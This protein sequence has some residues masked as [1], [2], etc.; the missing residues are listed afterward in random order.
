MTALINIAGQRFGRLLVIERCGSRGRKARW[1]CRCD[2]GAECTPCSEELRQGKTTSCG[3][4][5][6]EDL[7]T[8]RTVHGATRK[9][10]HW[11]EY[12][13]WFAMLNRCYRPQTQSFQYYGARGIRVCDRWRHGEGGLT[14]FQCFIADIGRRPSADHSID[15]IDNDGHY[16]P[17]NCR[18][19][20]ATEQ[21][22]NR[23]PRGT[24]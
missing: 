22:N 11:P 2:C 14:G 21:A 7:A 3:C 17:D 12:S 16:A 19:S 20:T 4:F 5:Q 8:R 6:R 24:A 1:K 18:W 13:L 15:R 10:R 23:R 9:E